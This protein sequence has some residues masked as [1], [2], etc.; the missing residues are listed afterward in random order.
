MTTLM[1]YE[2]FTEEEAR[3]YAAEIVLAVESIHKF[4]YIH[5]YSCVWNV[6]LKDIRL[7]CR[8]Y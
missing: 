5:R 1:K 6:Y 2:V 7:T 4:D 8:A 3:F